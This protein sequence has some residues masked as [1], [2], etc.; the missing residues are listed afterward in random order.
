MSVIGTFG[1]NLRSPTRM[2]RDTAH[3]VAYTSQRPCHN[4][5]PESLPL[6]PTARQ[7]DRH[8]RTA[9]SNHTLCRTPESFAN[10]GPWRAMGGHHSRRSLPPGEYTDAGLPRR[11]EPLPGATLETRP[12]LEL[13]PRR[14]LAFEYVRFS[15]Y[16]GLAVGIPPP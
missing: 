1:I 10:A 9:H 2:H 13:R 6:S 15:L 14:A 11:E 5:G 12:L 4:D 3:T 16:S 8:S 7:C